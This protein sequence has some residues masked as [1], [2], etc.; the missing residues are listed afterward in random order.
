MLW[1]MVLWVGSMQIPGLLLLLLL[2]LLVVV[3]AAAGFLLVGWW[4]VANDCAA[5]VPGSEWALLLLPGGAFA[6]ERRER[7]CYCPPGP[8]V[9]R[10]RCGCLPAYLLLEAGVEGGAHWLS[11]WLVSLVGVASRCRW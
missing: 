10:C 5:S 2:L 11:G 1:W 3:A 8:G 9:V 6:R 7:G 4:V